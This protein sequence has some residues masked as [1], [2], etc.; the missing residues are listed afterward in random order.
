MTSLRAD[1]QRNYARILAIAEQEVAEHGAEVSLEQI[2][3]LAGV[4]SATV[5][6]RFPSRQALLE[7]VFRERIDCC[8][9]P[10]PTAR[11][12]E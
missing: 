7:A 5:R 11:K 10:W 6:R 9:G 2:A 8:R 3:R 1:A 12:T 4:G